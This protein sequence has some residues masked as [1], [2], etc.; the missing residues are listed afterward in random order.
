MSRRKSAGEMGKV[1]EIIEK[2][3]DAEETN[4]GTKMSQYEKGNGGRRGVTRCA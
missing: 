3:E 4:A 2:R 1:E